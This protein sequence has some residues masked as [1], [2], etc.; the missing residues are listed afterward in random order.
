MTPI[1]PR[2]RRALAVVLALCAG[3]A[4]APLR[5][6]AECDRHLLVSGYNSNVH[7]YDGC[8]GAFLR[9]L[10]SQPG[11]LAG[12][13]ALRL[14][15]DGALWVVSEATEQVHR[16][17][18]DDFAFL[19]TPVA[20]GAGFGLTGID[21][22]DGAVWAGG[23]RGNVVRRYGLDGALQSTP[24]QGAAGRGFD[25]GLVFGPDGLLYIPAY[26]SHTVLRHDPAGGQTTTLVGAGSG[27]L[28]NTRGILFRPDGATFLVTSEGSGQILEYRRDSGALV[29]ELAR[30]LVRPTGMAFGPDGSLVVATRDGVLRLDPSSGANRGMLVPAGSGGLDG[31]TFVLFL[32]KATPVDRSQ[33]G[34]QFWISGPGR[35]DGRRVVVEAMYS[36]N[37]PVFGAGYDPQAIVS[38]RWGRLTLEFT[39]CTSATMGWDSTGADSAGFGSGGYVLSRFIPGPGTR[40]CEQAGFAQSPPEDW[41][42]GTWWGGSARSGEGFIFEYV[43]DTTVV[44]TWF[45]HRPAP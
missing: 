44:A 22:R 34:S 31:P 7:V 3:A 5:A 38:R 14:G 15:P 37:G 41:L 20:T 11:R 30:G 21:F 12:P 40:R 32:P 33:V 23:Y 13:Q 25:N 17:R 8:S 1:L 29:R 19:S 35:L 6:Q 4:A 45:T 18:A 42:Q 10:D 24:V 16:Y 2:W 39:G 28:R 26:Q 43:N 27:G 36:S 9:V